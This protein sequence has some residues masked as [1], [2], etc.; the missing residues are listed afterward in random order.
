MSYI[1]LVLVPGLLIAMWAQSRVRSA[2]AEAEQF[3]SRAGYSGA[4]LADRI[5]RG[6]GIADVEIEPTHGIL[7]DHYHPLAKALR[8]SEAHFHGRSLAAVGIAA[9]EAGHAIQHAQGYVPLQL[10]SALVPVCQVGQWIGQVAMMIGFLLWGIGAGQTLLLLAILGYAAVFA[11]TLVTLPVEYDA[12]ARALRVLTDR[13][14]LTADEL[15]VVRRV[16][17][18]AALTYVANAVQVLLVL[19]YLLSMYQRRNA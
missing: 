1:L 14:Y 13:G 10:R 6:A 16:L 11:F 15:P 7:T 17:S 3:V 5:L 9:H 2:Y 8:L 12:S 18:A 4:E 19:L